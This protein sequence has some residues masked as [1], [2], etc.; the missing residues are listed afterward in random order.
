MKLIKKIFIGI[1][2][3]A[4][5]QHMSFAAVSSECEK[6]TDCDM[7][8]ACE[9]VL[10]AEKAIAGMTADYEGAVA[11]AVSYRQACSNYPDLFK[12]NIDTTISDNPP[13]KLTINWENVRKRMRHGEQGNFNGDDLQLV[14]IIVDIL[15]PDTEAQKKFFEA[16]AT[17]YINANKADETARLNDA[18]VLDFLGTDDNFNK[19]RLVVRDLT[20]DVVNEDLGIDISW[21]AVLTEISNVL[22]QQEPKRG[23]IVCENNRSYQF[24]ID[25]AG[26]IVTAIAA[27]A[28]F[29]AGGAGGAAVATGRAAIGAGLKASAKVIAKAGGKAA[30]KSMSKAGSKQLAKSAVKLG[31]KA[32]M[33]GW[34]NYAGK[35]VLKT[36][37]KNFVKIAGQNLKNKWTKLAAGGAAL[38]V[39]GKST[40]STSST[41]YSLLSSDLD[42][43]YLNCRDLDHN[44]GCYTVCGDGQANDYINKYAL[45]PVLG[46][47]YCVNPDDYVM[48]EINPDGSRG[49]ALTFDGNKKTAILSRIKQ[50]VQDKA[51]SGEWKWRGFKS[52]MEF[53]GCDWNEDDIDMYIGLF[54]Y[55]PDTLEI[56]TE[57]MAIDEAIRLD[58]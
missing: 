52:H 14:Q 57:A 47:T 29:Y 21:D 19:Y 53:W 24:L 38:W 54:I 56:S 28:T 43:E 13:L 58:D 6:Y 32:N 12:K 48:Y 34:A 10:E 26:W 31:L 15:G 16:L 46:K 4:F 23:M 27:I 51:D 41:L 17:A 39:L 1:I 49:P 7:L 55:D 44:E 5:C 40:N 25:A 22:D 18:F 20:G 36:G 37:I 8:V 35:G 33:R 2:M 9:L 11:A 42:K 3:L 50:H 30:A 45:Q